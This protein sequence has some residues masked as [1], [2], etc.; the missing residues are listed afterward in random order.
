MKRFLVINADDAGLDPRL[1]AVILELARGPLKSASVLTTQKGFRQFVSRALDLGMGLGL[2]FD[3]T[4]GPALGG[5]Y[6]TLTDREGRFIT[7]KEKVWE[8]ALAGDI[9]PAEVAR[10]A[11][12]QWEALLEA[13][14]QPDHIDGHNH[15]HVLPGVFEGL[16]AALGHLT[17]VFLRIPL[18]RGPDTGRCPHVRRHAAALQS[19]PE[20]IPPGWRRVEVFTGHRFMERPGLDQLEVL[21]D[22]EVRTLEWMVH[23][24]DADLSPFRTDERR[25]REVE[26]LLSRE[27]AQRLDER[28]IVCCRFGDIPCES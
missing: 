13:G 12:L 26:I 11:R 9:D 17:D 23:P 21:D 5:P 14:V 8:R 7:P 10:E 25:R 18:G 3:L 27:L 22:D 20:R 1:D 24:G 6:E 19:H 4:T 15:V 28:G 16:V 2:H